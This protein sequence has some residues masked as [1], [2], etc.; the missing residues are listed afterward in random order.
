MSAP[1]LVPAVLQAALELDEVRTEAH[2]LEY[3][4]LSFSEEDPL[5]AWLKR[6]KARG[7]TKNTDDVLLNLLVHLHRKVDALSEAVSGVKR[8]LLSLELSVLTNEIGFEYVGFGEPVLIPNKRYYAR[9]SLPVFPKRDMAVY[10][11]AISQ[12]V[13]HIDVMHEDDRGDWDSFVASKEREM[14]RAM[15]V[16]G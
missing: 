6:A 5:G 1:R 16:G 11:G 13:A 10:L 8:E 7:E 12:S 4:S 15:R 2:A 14:I 3:G 9:I